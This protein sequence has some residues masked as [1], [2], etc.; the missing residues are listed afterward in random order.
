MP[1][2]PRP[3]LAWLVIPL[4]TL[5]IIFIC[6]GRV[7]LRA[8][9]TTGFPILLTTQAGTGPTTNIRLTPDTDPA[10]ESAGRPGPEQSTEGDSRAAGTTTSGMSSPAP[11]PAPMPEPGDADGW[12][13]PLPAPVTV[14]RGF[15]VPEHP[16]GPGHRGADLGAAP[17]THIQAARAGVVGFAGWIGD[18]WVV[19]IVHGALRTTYEP[20]RPLVHEGDAVAAGTAIGLL[21]PGHHDCPVPACLHWGVLRG[22]EYLDPLRFFR[23]ITPRLLPLA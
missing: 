21:E 5:L 22:S 13:W 17:G 18:R 15:L 7:P 8:S 6:P 12:R 16:Y 1:P 14:V 9:P 19:T 2:P 11:A 3:D 4:L 20:A 10:A 23:R